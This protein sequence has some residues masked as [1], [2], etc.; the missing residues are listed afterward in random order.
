MKELTTVGYEVKISKKDQAYEAIKEMIVT[1]KL[2]PNMFISERLLSEMIG[3]SR[4]PIKAALNELSRE[5]LVVEYPGRGFLVGQMSI[6]DLTEIYE[7]R[8]A[9]EPFVI[10][11]IVE[12]DMKWVEEEMT[13][14]MEEMRKALDE[15]DFQLAQECDMAFHDCYFK[16][17][18]NGRLQEMLLTLRDEIR[19]FMLL[20]R[21]DAERQEA[22]YAEHMKVLKCVQNRDADGS[23]NALKE[24]LLAS[25]QF[26]MKKLTSRSFE[27]TIG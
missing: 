13:I 25:Y 11:K 5:R 26:H 4:T 17:A 22:S 23:S 7:I 6:E 9:L 20:M 27:R 1:G 14:H 8:C 2:V 24:H 10:K 18:R 3:V 16:N 21:N 15:K 19:S 12:S